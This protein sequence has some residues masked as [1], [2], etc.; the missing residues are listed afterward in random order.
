[1]LKRLNR[2]NP[3]L[4][5]Y[6]AD[7][8]EN[9]HKYGKK[10]NYDFSIEIEFVEYE[11]KIPDEG[12]IY[13]PHLAGIEYKHISNNFYGTMPVQVGVCHG[14]NS[15]LNGLEYHM[16]SEIVV[17]VTDLVL[18]VA[19]Q[20]MMIEDTIDSK[21]VE[22]IYLEAGEAFEIYQTTLHFSPTKVN[23]DGFMSIIILLDGTNYDLVEDC[24]DKLLFKTNKWL[25]VHQEHKDRTGTGAEVGIYGDNIELKY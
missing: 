1:M 3:D 18:L 7:D 23:E 4:N 19:H 22:G 15:K 24:E 12:N 25:I 6:S 10:V 11:T 8:R 14:N 16:G 2:L 20:N 13:L 21:H 5:I 9:T 17:A